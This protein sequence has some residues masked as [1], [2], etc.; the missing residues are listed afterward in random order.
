MQLYKATH[1]GVTRY[2]A[3]KTDLPRLGHRQP[4]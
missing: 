4:G 3:L 2:R 1:M